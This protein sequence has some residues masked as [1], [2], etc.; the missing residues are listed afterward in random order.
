M[1]S[2]KCHIFIAETIHNASGVK[3]ANID[4]FFFCVFLF[5]IGKPFTTTDVLERS[6]QSPPRKFGRNRSSP[7]VSHSTKKSPKKTTIVEGLYS[8]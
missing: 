8:L 4:Y 3:M 6:T 7:D 1:Y 2:D 5:Y